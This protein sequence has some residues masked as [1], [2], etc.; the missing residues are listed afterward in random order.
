MKILI[1]NWQDITNP[2]GGGAESHLHEIFKRVAARGHEV[3]LYC[4]AHGTAPS[5]EIIDGIKIIREG[6]RNLF[7]FF[8][9]LRYFVRFR[10]EKFD[11]VIDDINKIPFYTPLFVREPIL[12]I[13]HH[14]FGKSIFLEA[15]KIAGSYVYAAEKFMDFVYMNTQFAVVSESTLEEFLK[16]GFNRDNFSIIP[17]CIDR[18]KYPFVLSQKNPT[19]VIAY[20]GRLKRYKSADHLLKAF[21][22][23]QKDVPNVELQILGTGDFRPELEKLARQLGIAEKT[24]FFGFVSDEKKLE[25]LSKAICMVNPSMKEGWGITNIEANACGTPVISANSPGLRDS[26][27]NGES[28]LLYEYGNVEEL[29]EKL[30]MILTDAVLSQKLRQGAISWAKKFNWENSAMLM[31]E[32]C[33]DVIAKKKW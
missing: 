2:L 27:S 5:E 9:P 24:T 1:F 33:K 4:C 18:E 21:A 30:R 6:N 13:S 31:I 26:V 15:G 11:I 23:I 29:A 32:R 16:R 8:V 17:N 28:G 25:L 3:T 20:F 7:N 19:P 12:A 14:F 22:L 10:H